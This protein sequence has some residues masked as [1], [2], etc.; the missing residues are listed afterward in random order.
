MAKDELTEKHLDLRKNFLD[1]TELIRSIQRA[2]GNIDCFRN[3]QHDCDQP[4]CAWR[5]YCL[6]SDQTPGRE[7]I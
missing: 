1:V 6:Q 2:E 7:E 3:A 5:L 4:D